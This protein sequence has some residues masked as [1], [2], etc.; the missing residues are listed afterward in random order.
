MQEQSSSILVRSTAASMRPSTCF[1]GLTSLLGEYAFTLG[2][3]PL[4]TLFGWRSAVKAMVRS[5]FSALLGFMLLFG[6]AGPLGAQG[7]T[8]HAVTDLSREGALARERKVPILLMFSAEYCGYCM[9]VEEEFLKPMLIS[10]DYTDRVIIRQL[11]V[12]SLGEVRDFDGRPIGVE[13]L[14]NRY[15][16][17]VTPTIVF[18]D[19][20]GRQMSQKMVGLTTPDFFGGYLDE[21]IETAL[22]RVRAAPVMQCQDAPRYNTAC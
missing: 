19:A 21:R 14:V 10:G 7:V 12:D 16:A 20:E 2:L 4:E 5:G 11:K 1:Q 17:F 18:L 9:R 8:V 3:S 15:G 22:S 13:A 6:A